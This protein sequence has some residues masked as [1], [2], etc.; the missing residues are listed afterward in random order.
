[1]PKAKTKKKKVSIEKPQE[2]IVKTYRE[3]NDLYVDDIP[4]DQASG[5]SDDEKK[6]IIAQNVRKVFEAYNGIWR[7]KWARK[8][9]TSYDYT[10]GDQLTEDQEKELKADGM[11]TFIIN[12]LTPII[13]LMK[14]FVTDNLPRWTGVGREGSDSDVAHLHSTMSDYAFYHSNGKEQYS[15]IIDNCFRRSKGYWY[16]YLDKNADRGLGDILF[17]SINSIYVYVDPHAQDIFERDAGAMIIKGDFPKSQL[18]RELP[19]YEQQIRKATCENDSISISMRDE[20]SSISSQPGDY[21]NPIDPV[22]GMEDK[23]VGYYR[24]FEKIRVPYVRVFIRIPPSPERM[25]KINAIVQSENLKLKQEL[26]VQYKEKQ[27]EL[28]ELVNSDKIIKDRM[29]LELERLKEEHNQGLATKINTL[30]TKMINEYSV[31]DEKDIPESEY[32]ILVKNE[33]IRQTIVHVQSYYKTR[34]KRTVSVG[35]D[36]LLYSDIMNISEYPLIAL[37]YE[38]TGT[39]Y[40]ISAADPLIGK[41]EEI[42]HAHRIMIHNANLGSN[43]RWLMKKGQAANP[44]YWDKHGSAPG[45]RLEWVDIDGSGVPPKEILPAQLNNAFFSIIEMGKVDLEFT[46][47]VTSSQMGIASSQPEPYRGI[48]ANDEFGMRQIKT[49]VNTVLDPFLTH[50]GKVY[51]EMAQ[52]FYTYHKVFRITQ[53]N[54]DSYEEKVVEVNMPIYDDFGN[55]ITKYNDL[56]STQYDVV[57]VSGSSMPTNRQ[58]EEAKYFE[59]YKEDAIPKTTFIAQTDIKNK[60]KV[61]E[62]IGEINQLKR[63]V[64]EFEKLIKDKEGTIETLERQLVQAGIKMKVLQ[65]DNEVRKELTEVKA[66]SDLIKRAMKIIL[67]YEKKLAKTKQEKSNGDEKTNKK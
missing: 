27:K 37:P 66:E 63:A 23:M 48:L 34:I 9:Q 17:K 10:L 20:N 3:R 4:K 52:N 65:A 58:A 50:V 64:G 51:Q 60:E 18:I 26:A 43:I 13:R 31:I 33:N 54:Q 15:L 14:Y 36:Q 47:P 29:D 55:V 61:I 6:K 22:T 24:K 7:T 38:H 12:L 35:T 2:I 46:S 21:T 56:S 49:W 39:P 1:M 40:P 30:R 5:L 19:E 25:K 41:Q 32:D 59:Y 8:S 28:Y 11:P 42:N 62:E 44:K 67:E 57:V 16:W 45:V 53:P